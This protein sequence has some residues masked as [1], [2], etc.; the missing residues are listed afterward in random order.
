MNN[1]NCGDIILNK[2]FFKNSK[3][4]NASQIESNKY[5]SHVHNRNNNPLNCANYTQKV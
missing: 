1:A 2:F 5:Y 4:F 3:T